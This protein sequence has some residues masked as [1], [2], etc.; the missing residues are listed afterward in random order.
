MGGI[1]DVDPCVPDVAEA[2]VTVLL[3]A[4]SNEPANR[5][6]HF[7]RQVGHVG[8]S[9]QH[10]RQDVGPKSAERRFV[11]EFTDAAAAGRSTGVIRARYRSSAHPPTRRAVRHRRVTRP[12][13]LRG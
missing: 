8:L 1:A 12:A 9:R 7:R 13:T 5:C 10:R 11:T 2:F 4:T 3:E 6:G